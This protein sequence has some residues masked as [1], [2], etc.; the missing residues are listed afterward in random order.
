M[1]VLFSLRYQETA[2]K[3]FTKGLTGVNPPATLHRNKNAVTPR[4]S[5]VPPSDSPKYCTT[6]HTV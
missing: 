5:S 1:T 6:T 4:H 3:T 2:F